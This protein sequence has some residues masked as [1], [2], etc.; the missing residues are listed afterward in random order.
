MSLPTGV[1]SQPCARPVFSE[2]LQRGIK[3]TKASPGV[4]SRLCSPPAREE[5]ASLPHCHLGG[6]W[7]GRH[8]HGFIRGWFCDL[9]P[10]APARVGAGSQLCDTV[11]R[12]GCKGERRD[13]HRRQDAK[14]H[15]TAQGSKPSAF[16]SLQQLPLQGYLQEATQH[17]TSAAGS[18][19]LC[20][21]LFWEQEIP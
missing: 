6:P 20:R 11:L 10:T 2:R 16:P 4:S 19:W 8:F 15:V 9:S 21:I 5:G 12:Q 1:E 14:C 3:G 7:A 18:P 17:K 13:K